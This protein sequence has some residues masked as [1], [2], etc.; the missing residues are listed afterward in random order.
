MVTFLTLFIGV[1][2][3]L[4]TVQVAVTPPVARVELRLNG[5]QVATMRAPVWKTTLSRKGAGKE[6]CRA[7]RSARRKVPG[8]PFRHCLVVPRLH[9]VAIVWSR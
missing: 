5:E 3:G 8:T 7:R 2:S 1:V 6:R 4:Q 9:L